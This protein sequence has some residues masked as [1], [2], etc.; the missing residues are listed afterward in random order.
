[1]LIII[2]A[3]VR[4]EAVERFGVMDIISRIPVTNIN[5]D[6]VATFPN[7]RDE[8]L[9]EF[10]DLIVIPGK[11]EM[12]DFGSEFKIAALQEQEIMQQLGLNKLTQTNYAACNYIIFMYLT[13]CNTVIDDHVIQKSYSI[14]ADVSARIID[15]NTGKCVL[16]TTGSG[17][18]SA[19]DYRALGM[20]RFKTFACPEDQFYDALKTAVHEIAIKIKE[21]MRV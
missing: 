21:R 10:D 2:F 3:N 15:K 16:V 17:V 20:F 6:V 1:M 5:N 4:A 7:A 14:K 12:V 13:N 19:K 9:A 11:V 8:I 18:S